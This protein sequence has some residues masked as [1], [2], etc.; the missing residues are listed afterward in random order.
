MNDDP[1]KPGDSALG[2]SLIQRNGAVRKRSQVRSALT[3]KERRRRR[4]MRGSSKA[5]VWICCSRHD[6]QRSRGL[7]PVIRNRRMS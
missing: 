5:W 1:G 2:L 7:A 3:G 4:R 6:G